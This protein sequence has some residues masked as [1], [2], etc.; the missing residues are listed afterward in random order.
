MSGE[1]CAGVEKGILELF[2]Y[3]KD[4]KMRQT[5]TQ[6]KSSLGIRV[7]D[8]DT[9]STMRHND[10]V[11][12]ITICDVTTTP[13]MSYDMYVIDVMGLILTRTNRV[14]YK[15]QLSICSQTLWFEFCKDP[16]ETCNVGCSTLVST[17]SCHDAS[18]FDVGSSRVV[19][20]S[21]DEMAKLTIEVQDQERYRYR[22]Q[23]QV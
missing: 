7:S 13:N 23:Y 21:L 1:S 4:T 10:L 19:S 17:H 15:T 16:K 12:N 2:I 9:F 22:Y 5:I 14:S 20:Y 8:T 11:R 3:R 18:G 6:H